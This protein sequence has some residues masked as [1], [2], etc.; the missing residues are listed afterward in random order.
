MAALIAEL[1]IREIFRAAHR[2]QQW[3]LCP[4]LTAKL[5]FFLVIRL[6]FWTFHLSLSHAEREALL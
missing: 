6:A 2:A 1:I 4:T 5:G 3:E